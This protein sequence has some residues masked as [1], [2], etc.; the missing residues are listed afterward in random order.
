[1]GSLRTLPGT[2]LEIFIVSQFRKPE[3]SDAAEA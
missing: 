3:A 2:R 1:M